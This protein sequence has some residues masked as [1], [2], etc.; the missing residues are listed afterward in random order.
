MTPDDPETEMLQ[1]CNRLAR[2]VAEMPGPMPDDPKGA[3]EYGAHYVLR[4]LFCKYELGDP[5]NGHEIM[6]F[7]VGVIEADMDNRTA[8][9]L[10]KEIE[11][12]AS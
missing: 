12:A 9:C 8:H 1:R 5:V 3:T 2:R 11:E 6:E 4:A 10:L 7:L